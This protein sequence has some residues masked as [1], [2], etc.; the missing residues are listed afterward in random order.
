MQTHTLRSNLVSIIQYYGA[1]LDKQHRR[2]SSYD[3]QALIID[4]DFD[5]S[6]P[7]ALLTSC[8]QPEKAFMLVDASQLSRLL[9]QQ[10]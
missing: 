6:F 10:Q 4:A 9:Y 2:V 3:G 7:A 5:H 1:H 8:T